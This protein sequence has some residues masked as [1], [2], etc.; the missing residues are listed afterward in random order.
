MGRMRRF[1]QSVVFYLPAMLFMA[2]AVSGQQAYDPAA[3]NL[4]VGGPQDW[5]NQHVLY[6]RNGSLEDAMQVRDDPR[7]VSSVVLRYMR[8]H[9]GQ[10]PSA[11]GPDESGLNGG[12]NE[13]NYAADSQ[14]A[15]A[16]ELQRVAP[17]D[18]LRPLPIPTPT[19][20]QKKGDWAVSLGPTAG[21]ALGESPAVYTANY[22]SPSCAADFV[23]YT[24]NAAPNTGAGTGQANLVALNNL[25]TNGAGTGFCTGTGPSFL[26]SY[27]IGSGASPLSPVLSEDG[28]RVAWIENTSAGH[29][30]LHVTIWVAGEGA[31]ATAPVTPSGTFTNG[32][33]NPSA[34]ACDFALDYTSQTPPGCNTAYPA[35]NTHSDLFVDYTNDVGYISANNGLL[36][37][38]S[39]L[40]STTISPS[41][42][43]CVPVNATFETAPK[44]AM[45]GPVYD[46]LLNEVF[47]SDSEKLYAYTVN[48]SA[49]TP[50]F[51]VTTPASYTF[52]NSASNYNY[53]TGPGPLLDVFNKW[54][55]VFS[56]Y[57]AAG[58][59]SV[60]QVP[61]PLTATAYPVE[62]GPRTT[63]A[64]QILFYGA[65]DNNYINNGP[66]SALSTLYS[67][68]TDSGTTTAQDLFAIS[69]NASTGQ[70]NPTPAMSDNTHVNPS[71]TAGVCS[72]L[73]EF[74]DG[75]TD[76]LF[77]G[78]GEPGNNGGSNVVTVWNIQNQ[79]TS[80]SDT[81]TT[82]TLAVYLGGTSGISADNNASGTAQGENIYFSTEQVGTASTPVPATTAYTINGI[83][84]NGHAIPCGG[85]FDHDGNAYSHTLLGASLTWN[86]TTFTFG[87]TNAV[88]AWAAQTVTFSAVSGSYN[89]I[90]LLAAGVNGNLPSQT[91]I[92][93]YSDTTTQT[94]TQS[95][96][97]WF[98][99]QKYPGESVAASYAYRNVCP[100]G[101]EGAGPFQIYGYSF[102]I[103]A[104]K[105]V[106]SITLPAVQTGGEAPFYV[107]VVL[108]ISLSSN[109]GGADYC[110]VKLTQVGL[111]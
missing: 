78:M 62:L 5:S 45:S 20:R 14:S 110:A 54:L 72:P 2:P 22:S 98:T 36:Y 42:A 61:I 77:V 75:T 4:M 71:G 80:A 55:Y 24:I 94:F 69:F 9:P 105:T 30:V 34:S 1:A 60:T 25:Y 106:A 12:M 83:Y 56:T 74:Y 51:G 100:N 43:F 57:D 101:T 87:P 82:T 95:V 39:N 64:N 29:A 97:D 67:C 15:D 44:A 84:S 85:G 48:A 18:P 93:T 17:W 37:Y 21:M 88:D 8:E 6:T 40:F 109:C 16:G 35:I 28:T 102:P 50:N 11:A 32:T 108:A 27:A 23:V 52:G 59:T 53:P 99:P 7:F 63:N 66:K 90:N 58:E 47:I 38:I 19:P 111:Q 86:G 73:T 96:S 46:A 81:P 33:C 91:F 10:F 13:N 89:T 107:V 3:P 76:R 92:V 79:L 31:T 103:N 68:G 41:V 26:F 49:T 65:F 70:V 104:N